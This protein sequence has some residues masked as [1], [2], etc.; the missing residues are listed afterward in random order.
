MPALV[1]APKAKFSQRILK[2]TGV[3][4]AFGPLTVG[5]IRIFPL[6]LALAGFTRKCVNALPVAT[7]SSTLNCSVYTPAA[8]AV[9]LVEV[10]VGLPNTTGAG[11]LT[12]LQA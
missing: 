3:F 6:V 11:P 5:A 9:T 12:K 4:T 8:V 2:D 7:P 1:A 10:E